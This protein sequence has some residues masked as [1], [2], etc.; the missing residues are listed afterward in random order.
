M[1]Q[2]DHPNIIRLEGV[3]TRSKYTCDPSLKEHFHQSVQQNLPKWNFRCSGVVQVEDKTK[4]PEAS[5]PSIQTESILCLCTRVQ[6]QPESH[7]RKTFTDFGFANVF[8]K[9]LQSS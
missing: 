2:F 1:G 8:D 4:I 3:V 5:E 6:A 9:W 7:Q